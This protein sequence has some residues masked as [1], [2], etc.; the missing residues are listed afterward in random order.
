MKNAMKPIQKYK[1]TKKAKNTK[2]Q[3]YKNT[4]IQK[5]KKVKNEPKILYFLIFSSF[6]IF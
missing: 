3:K 5:Y 6:S 2:M 4:K 1:N